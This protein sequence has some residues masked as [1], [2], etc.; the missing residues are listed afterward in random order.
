MRQASY[1]A[2]LARFLASETSLGWRDLPPFRDGA[3]DAAC[4]AVD[5]EVARGHVIGPAPD[6]VFAA[7]AHTPI[8]AVKVITLGQDPYPTPGDADGLAFSH[9]GHGRLPRSL[10][11]I[12][13][14]MAAD[15]GQA[16]PRSGDLTAWARQ[17]VLLLN[18]ALTVSEGAGKAG[19]HLK[20]GWDGVTDG[21]IAGACAANPHLVAM[22]WGAHAQKRRELIDERQ[23]LVI[24]S[25]HPSPLSARRGFF[26]SRPFSR[27]NDWL[28]ANGI[29]PVEWSKQQ[30]KA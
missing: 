17:G 8:A 18:T 10:A 21:I 23:H 29:M 15:L 22:L 20:L 13:A 24:A 14:E 26:G 4:A 5:G 30:V 9:A 2:A 27:A 7:L 25:A 11:N 19:A 1:Q 28:A 16:A 12:F 3:A 6:R